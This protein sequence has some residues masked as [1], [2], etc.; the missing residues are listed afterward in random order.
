M[1]GPAGTGKGAKVRG[2][3]GNAGGSG[4]AVRCF[5]EE[6]PASLSEGSQ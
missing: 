6:G 2:G 4:V 5:L 3:A 1:I